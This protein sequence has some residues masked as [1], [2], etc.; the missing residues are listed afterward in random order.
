[1]SDYDLSVIVQERREARDA[2]DR[3]MMLNVWGITPE[4]QA[5]IDMAVARARIRLDRAERQY[6]E[7]IRREAAKD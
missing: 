2:F 7:I 6:D 5:E 4:Q 3:L 1:M